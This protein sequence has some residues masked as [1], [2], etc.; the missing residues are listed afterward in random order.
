SNAATP[1]YSA[2]AG[3]SSCDSLSSDPVGG[4]TATF[5]SGSGTCVTYPAGAIPQTWFGVD[6]PD[7]VTT[8]NAVYEIDANDMLFAGNNTSTHNPTMWF[9]D[10]DEFVDAANTAAA[11]NTT[12]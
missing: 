12:G 1:V 10:G 2:N 5:A 3:G 6:T 8:I 7:A 11:P 9:S 4:G